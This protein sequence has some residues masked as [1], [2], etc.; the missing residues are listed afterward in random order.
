MCVYTTSNIYLYHSYGFIHDILSVFVSLLRFVFCFLSSIA[1]L[2][3]AYKSMCIE[4]MG[5]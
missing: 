2:I 3:F 1:L 5:H 4:A